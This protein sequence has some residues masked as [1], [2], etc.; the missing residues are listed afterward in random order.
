MSH[1]HAKIKDKRVIIAAAVSAAA[2]AATVIAVV[3]V[4]SFH[5]NEKQTA[6]ANTVPSTVSQKTQVTSLTANHSTAESKGSDVASTITGETEPPEDE[7]TEAY[8]EEQTEALDKPLPQPLQNAL[9]LIGANSSDLYGT[10]LILV[11]SSQNG[12]SNATVRLYQKNGDSWQ[13]ADGF[14]EISAFVGS[15]GV[16]E[17]S[18]GVSVTPMGLFGIPTAFG[19]DGS[20]DTGLDY[21][22]I[23][24]DTYWVDDP[25]SRY[26]NQRVENPEDKDWESAEHMIDFPDNYSC[27]FVFDY[28]MNPAAPG[29]GSAFFMHVS[30]QPTHGCVGVSQEDMLRILQWLRQDASPQILIV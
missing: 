22:Q 11:D 20:I 5:R 17:A 28:N 4:I 6:F 15:E 1:R 8:T 7:L 26:Y 12:G 27:G 19:F 3:L 25:N 2:L 14:E 18:E 13:A 24:D 29:M 10:Q 9:S 23:T 16:G 30:T 21:F